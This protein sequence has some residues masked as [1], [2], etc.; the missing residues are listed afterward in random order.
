M[1]KLFALLLAAMMI[2]SFAACS[3]DKKTDTDPTKVSFEAP[4]PDDVTTATIT[5]GKVNGNTY[6]NASAGISFTLPSGWRFYSDSELASLINSAV[7][8]LNDEGFNAAL[9]ST[10]TVYDMMAL[11]TTTNENVMIVFE[12]TKKTLGKD[13]TPTE[14]VNTVKSQLAPMGYVF[15]T[16]SNAT[17]G[18]H[19]YVQASALASTNGVNL[20]QYYYCRSIDNYLVSI[21]TTSNGNTSSGELAALFN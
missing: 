10:G 9:D 17:L 12:N 15:S 19:S 21:I 13:L 2:L 1:K 14:Y 7:D 4:D 5:R 8:V 18:G 6:T 16:V 20:E 11:N 3:D